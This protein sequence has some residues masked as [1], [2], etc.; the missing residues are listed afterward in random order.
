MFLSGIDWL[1]CIL[2]SLPGILG[3]EAVKYLA[4][5]KNIKF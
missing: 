2:L 4:R 5:R 3:I 1:F